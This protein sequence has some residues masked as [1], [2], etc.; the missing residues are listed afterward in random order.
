LAWPKICSIVFLRR[1]TTYE[2][3]EIGSLP[4]Q[5]V[6]TD[7]AVDS[8]GFTTCRFVQWIKAKYT[9]PKLMQKHSWIKVHLVCGVKTNIVTSIEITDSR[10][11][12]CPRFKALVNTAARNFTMSQVSA[13]KAYFERQSANCR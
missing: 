1:S 8:S 6:E 9:D 13:D 4:L 12:D 7:F 11:N 5:T 2:L 10:A 3:I